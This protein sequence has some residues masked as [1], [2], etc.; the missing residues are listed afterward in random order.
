M[1]DTDFDLLNVQ[2]SERLQRQLAATLMPA[3]P[4]QMGAALSAKLKPGVL[5]AAAPRDSNCDRDAV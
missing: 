3:L 4:T 5:M 1:S 2:V